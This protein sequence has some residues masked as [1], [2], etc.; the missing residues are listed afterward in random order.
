MPISLKIESLHFNTTT[1]TTTLSAQLPTTLHRSINHQ[2]TICLH[3]FWS[4][5]SFLSS[6]S[7]AEHISLSSSDAGVAGVSDS[8]SLST[9]NYFT[10]HTTT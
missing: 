3:R 7:K 6:S 4:G 9:G 2:R 8:M 10:E 1:T 5:V